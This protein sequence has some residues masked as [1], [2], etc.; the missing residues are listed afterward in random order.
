MSDQN[1][2]THRRVFTNGLWLHVV[3]K[4]QGPNVLLI[5]GFP[6]LWLSWRNQIDHL[7][8]HG[9]RVIVPNMRGYGD[10]D[11][12][13]NLTSYTVFHLVGDLIGLLDDLGVEQAFVVGHDWGA[14][15]A[16]YLCLFRPDRVRA[17]INL[18]LPYRPPSLKNKPTDIFSNV[19]GDGFYITQFQ[20]CQLILLFA[21]YFEGYIC[22][23]LIYCDDR[24]VQVELV[25]SFKIYII[26]S[27]PKFITLIFKRRTRQGRE[28]FLK[29]D[30]S[31]IL[32]KFLLVDAPDLLSA[33]SNVEIIDFLQTPTSLPSWISGNYGFQI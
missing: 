8:N 31:T 23:I 18:G 33:P 5:H 22:R 10:S 9:Y 32:K 28:I 17:L 1:Q 6:E 11:S 14:E 7:T 15:V 2:L 21:F 19:Y 16:W 12:P 13:S 4:G 30:C 24:S 26:H 3:E 20:V 25:I 29:Y 27:S